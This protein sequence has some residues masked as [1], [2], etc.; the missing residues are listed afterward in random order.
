MATDR[1]ICANCGAGI[2]PAMSV[3]PRCGV[4]LTVAKQNS[5]SSVQ[6]AGAAATPALDQPEKE[7][8][9]RAEQASLSQ[10]ATDRTSTNPEPVLPIRR[11]PISRVEVPLYPPPPAVLLSPEEEARR[12]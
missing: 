8:T 10:P 2:S 11:P 3:C 6:A 7:T 5:P 4:A 1:L 12:L 9:A